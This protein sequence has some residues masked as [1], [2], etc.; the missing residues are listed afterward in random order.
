MLAPAVLPIEG[1]PG[2]H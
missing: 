1:A 2:S